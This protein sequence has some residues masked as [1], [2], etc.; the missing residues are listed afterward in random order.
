MKKTN[1]ELRFIATRLQRPL[2]KVKTMTLQTILDSIKNYKSFGCVECDI[3]V[4]EH[5]RDK[6]SEMC[7]IFKNTDISRD[8][9]GEFMKSVPRKK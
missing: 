2:D 1:K 9:I 4:P 7:P 5:L 3:H 6:F 8:D